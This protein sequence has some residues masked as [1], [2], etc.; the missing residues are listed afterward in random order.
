MLLAD[1]PTENANKASY[2]LACIL[3]VELHS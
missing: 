3:F 2:Q 1:T